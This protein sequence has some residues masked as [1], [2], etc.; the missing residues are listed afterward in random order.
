MAYRFLRNGC[1]VYAVCPPGHA[2]QHVRGI[3]RV[4]TYRSLSSLRAL[5]R[6]LLDSKADYVVPCNDGVVWQLH[7]LHERVP[8]LRPMIERSLGPPESFPI[9]RSRFQLLDTAQRLGIRIP[10]TRAV[11]SEEDI[12]AWFREFPRGDVAVKMDGAWGGIGVKLVSSEARALEAFQRFSRKPGPAIVAKRMLVDHDPLAFW[13]WRHAH[14]PG[15][16]IQQFVDGRPANSM[17]AARNGKVLAALHVEVLCAQGATKSAISIR[18][19]NSPEMQRAAELIAAELGL[20]GFFGL[21]YVLDP[22]TGRTWMLELNPRA[23]QMGHLEWLDDGSTLIDAYSAALTGHPAQPPT[24]PIPTG[25]M[26]LLFPQVLACDLNS[27]WLRGGVQDLPYDHPELMEDFLNPYNRPVGLLQR[28]YTAMRSGNDP[29]N[30]VIFSDVG[31]VA[32]D[33]YHHS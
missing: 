33:E 19:V 23:T 18:R 1:Q 10:R 11:E 24:N 25:S 9:L 32:A 12:H 2:L 7:A 21:D 6:G 16:S 14:Q 30:P 31:M 28:L 3:S 5:R 20:N 22:A 13:N 27:P 8:E 17:V 15:I 26:V 29:I 4:Y